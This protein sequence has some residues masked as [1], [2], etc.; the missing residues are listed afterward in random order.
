MSVAV[1]TLE[2]LRTWR[3]NVVHRG[4]WK[5]GLIVGLIAGSIQAT[6][7]QGDAWL[8]LAVDGPVLLKTVLSLLIAVCVALAAV[9]VASRP[10]DPSTISE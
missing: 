10:E 2:T 8:H 6:V 3:R 5:R 4:A 7:H 9:A 1:A